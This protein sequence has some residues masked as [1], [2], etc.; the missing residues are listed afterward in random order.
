MTNRVKGN[1]AV[2][3]PVVT[4]GIAFVSTEVLLP[5]VG[6]MTIGF[7][8]FLMAVL[9]LI[10]VAI[11]KKENL[12]V[13]KKDFKYFGIG[14]IVGIAM[15][16]YFENTGIGYVSATPASLIIALIPIATLIGDKIIYKRILSK[17]D[18]LAVSISLIGV[19][20][21]IGADLKNSFSGSIKGYV[22]MFGAV[23]CW[24]VYS[25]S[26][27]ILFEKY[28]YIVINIYQILVSLVI[29]FPFSFLEENLWSEFDFI[30]IGNLIFLGV[31]C[32]TIAFVFYSMAMDYLGI[33]ETALYINFLPIVTIIFSYFYLGNTIAPQQIFGGALVILSVTMSTL[34]G[35]KNEGKKEKNI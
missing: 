21:I 28:S 17:T 20:F 33:Y 23:V 27:K 34:Q 19:Y 32:S 11:Y 31:F 12:K 14:G 26:T 22:Y 3:V 30:I 10:P 15:Y 2:A 5:I 9:I 35:M 16:F 7:I 6:P 4:W 25:A 8:R 13:E 29:F 18:I 24:V 1:L